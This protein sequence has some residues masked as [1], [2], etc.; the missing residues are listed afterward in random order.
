[1][2]HGGHHDRPPTRRLGAAGLSLTPTTN[3]CARIDA[4]VQGMHGSCCGA[5]PP[6]GQLTAVRGRRVVGGVLAVALVGIFATT[7][8]RRAAA[9]PLTRDADP[10]VLTGA[11]LPT[12]VNGPTTTIVGFRSTASGW[13][14][15]P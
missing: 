4:L 5:T 14:Q 15:L 6:R 7:P 13:V 10:V 11:E 3:D 1:M 12:L 9:A 2:R 8:V